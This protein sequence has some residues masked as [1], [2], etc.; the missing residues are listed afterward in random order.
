MRGF[1]LRG[2]VQSTLR[3]TKNC[4][5]MR[6]FDVAQSVH[7]QLLLFLLRVRCVLAPLPWSVVSLSSVVSCLLM[8]S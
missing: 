5:C 7:L 4:N 2:E 3:E 6:C 1:L 8:H